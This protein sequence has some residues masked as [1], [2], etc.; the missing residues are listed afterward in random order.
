MTKLNQIIAVEKGVRAEAVR[1]KTDL[2]HALEKKPLFSGLSKTYKP[3]DEDDGEKLPSESVQVQIKSSDVL[4]QLTAALTRLFDITA[5]KDLANTRAKADVKLPDGTVI[6]ANVPVTTLMFFEKQLEDLA[7]FIGRLPQLDPA[8]QWSYDANRGVYVTPP[9][10]TKSTK[11]LPRNHVLYEATEHHPAQVQI[12]TEDKI[13]GYWTKFDFSGA[14]KADDITDIKI[15]L[16]KLRTAVK[17]AREEAN[18][19][20]VLDARY[21]ER[22][23]KY[24]FD[25]EGG[26]QVSG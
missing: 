13:V 12:F 25:L 10:E 3:L 8:Q 1:V 22:M 7:A 17:F 16:D 18:M 15:R 14:M 19:M 11:K 5:T 6:A 23:L 24:L 21:G 26:S 2:Y 9:I 20:D 4:K